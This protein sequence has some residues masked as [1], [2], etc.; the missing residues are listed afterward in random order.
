MAQPGFPALGSTW[1]SINAFKLAAYNAAR[2]FLPR[3]PN[4]LPLTS[5]PVQAQ[6]ILSIRNSN[7][8]LVLLACPLYKDGC[9]HR[10]SLR[11]AGPDEPLG[12]V[13]R[14]LAHSHGFFSGE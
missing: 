12:V 4:R 11:R 14:E 5:A 7:P 6:S 9:S 8:N 1:P 10:I 13:L 2:G 3:P